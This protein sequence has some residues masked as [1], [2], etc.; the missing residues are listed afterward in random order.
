VSG[1]GTEGE[2]KVR[3]IQDICVFNL[4]KLKQKSG[5]V[6]KSF[7]ASIFYLNFELSMSSC[8]T[9]RPLESLMPYTSD[10]CTHQ[11]RMTHLKVT[12]R[13]RGNGKR[14]TNSDLVFGLRNLLKE[15]GPG[16]G[17]PK[18]GVGGDFTFT[19]LLSRME[20]TVCAPSTSVWL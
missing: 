17:C 12:L 6:G 20:S 1:K 11:Q 5:E 16:G 2:R 13:M 9:K 3:L 10:G 8:S 4:Q 14:L 18:K 7:S 15:P 19:G